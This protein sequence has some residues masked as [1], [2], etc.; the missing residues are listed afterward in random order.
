MTATCPAFIWLLI[1]I[2]D[3]QVIVVPILQSFGLLF[4]G[5]FDAL[6]IT[7][8]DASVIIN[9]NAAFGMI[10]GKESTSAHLP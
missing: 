8:T 3:F 7:G 1:C 6:E 5:R 4:K 9:V 2:S 10:L